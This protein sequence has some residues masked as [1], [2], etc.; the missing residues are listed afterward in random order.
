MTN[1]AFTLAAYKAFV[2]KPYQKLTF[3]ICPV[4]DYKSGM[5]NNFMYTVYLFDMNLA[6][7]NVHYLLQTFMASG[8]IRVNRA[9]VRQM[10]SEK[11]MKLTVLSL[12]EDLQLFGSYLVKNIEQLSGL[13]RRP[14][15]RPTDCIF[16]GKCVMCRLILFNKRLRL[17]AEVRELK[18]QEYIERSRWNDAAAGEMALALSPVDQLLARR[19]VERFKTI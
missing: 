18:V 19:W 11:R 4:D 15:A 14:S 5:L 10:E 1:E 16:L 6:F 17:R 13:L 2:G 12:T 7:T 9:A 3:Y 8:N